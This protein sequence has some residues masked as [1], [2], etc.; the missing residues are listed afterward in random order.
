DTIWHGA[1]LGQRAHDWVG[2][3]AGS[4]ATYATMQ[5]NDNAALAALT[6]AS[7]AGKLDA[8]RAIVLHAV[9]AF[10]RP[11]PNQTAYDSLLADPG[12]RASSLDNLVIAGAPLVD[13]IVAS[14]SAWQ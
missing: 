11:H 3:V 9:W 6:V 13:D 4:G 14:W 2:V 1:L 7:N 12:A 5:Q 10:D 8:K